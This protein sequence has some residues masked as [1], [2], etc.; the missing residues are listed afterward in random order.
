VS[1]AER[2]AVE[3]AGGTAAATTGASAASRGG[4]AK[5]LGVACEGG[6]QGCG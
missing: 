4:Q 3:A 2:L 5:L 6:R 1:R